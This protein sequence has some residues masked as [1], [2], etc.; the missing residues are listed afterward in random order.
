MDP[1]PDP[2]T[3]P[4]GTYFQRNYREGERIEL[5]DLADWGWDLPGWGVSPD[6][7]KRDKRWN[8]DEEKEFKQKIAKDEWLPGE[9]IDWKKLRLSKL[10]FYPHIHETPPR[11]VLRENP[12]PLYYAGPLKPIPGFPSP[13]HLEFKIWLQN[14][15]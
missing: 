12:Y 4:I 9:W 3:D 11:L 6:P 10:G 14:K 13:G 8:S 1:I 2:P 7:K 5:L 15:I